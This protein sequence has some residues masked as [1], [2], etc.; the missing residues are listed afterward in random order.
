MKGL[1]LQVHRETQV[2]QPS[3]DPPEATCSRPALALESGLERIVGGVNAQPQ[4]VELALPQIVDARGDA[5][6]LDRGK[7]F[8]WQWRRLQTA[9]LAHAGEGVVVRQGHDADPGI[10]GGPD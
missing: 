7:K 2:S 9:E 5:V 3:D 6:D 10:G 1:G 8:E 4:D